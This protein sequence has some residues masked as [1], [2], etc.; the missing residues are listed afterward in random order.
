MSE[1][2]RDHAHGKLPRAYPSL[3]SFGV[4]YLSVGRAT[5]LIVRDMYERNRPPFDKLL[6][7][8]PD[9]SEK[10]AK[11]KETLTL[12]IRQHLLAAIEKGRLHVVSKVN[13]YREL[14]S[15]EMNPRS[16][17]RTSFMGTW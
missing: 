3:P 15:T 10:L 7:A 5:E 17:V 11:L 14:S 2:A 1:P 6:S 9:Y 12:K 4:L 13:T 16:H 8:T